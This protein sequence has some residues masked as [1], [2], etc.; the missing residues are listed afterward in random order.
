M[1][2]DRPC[3]HRERTLKQASRMPKPIFNIIRADKPHATRN[4]VATDQD[5]LIMRHDL[6]PQLL[7][8]FAGAVVGNAEGDFIQ[9]RRFQ[10]PDPLDYPFAWRR[11]AESSNHLWSQE[12][13][14]A[15]LDV[16]R[17]PLMDLQSS[18]GRRACRA[19]RRIRHDT[20]HKSNVT[21][22]E[23]ARQPQML[24]TARVARPPP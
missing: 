3:N 4:K 20:F 22:T 18:G 9:P 12:R 5:P 17:M 2:F 24:P 13:F 23:A 19:C 8:S 6:P 15:W 11:H 1:P 7:D 10:F 14:F 16:N 21:M